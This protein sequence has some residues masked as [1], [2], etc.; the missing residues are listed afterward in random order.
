MFLSF[1]TNKQNFTKTMGHLVNELNV[2]QDRE[3]SQARLVPGQG[4]AGCQRT[5]AHRTFLRVCGKGA[6]TDIS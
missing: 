3:G 4:E 5:C 1:L 2:K 6:D